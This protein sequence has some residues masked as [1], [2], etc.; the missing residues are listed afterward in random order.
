DAL[1]GTLFD[2]FTVGFKHSIN[3]HQ[4]SQMGVRDAHPEIART[5]ARLIEPCWQG[6]GDS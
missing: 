5:H 4:W 3:P 1:G 6:I 2:M